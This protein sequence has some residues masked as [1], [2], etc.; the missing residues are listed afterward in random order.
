MYFVFLIDVLT[1]NTHLTS[2]YVI[3]K[4]QPAASHFLGIFQSH[5]S[6]QS[7]LPPSPR[8]IPVATASLS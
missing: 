7:P 3:K 6:P 4:I 2:V 5:L 1:K 8:D